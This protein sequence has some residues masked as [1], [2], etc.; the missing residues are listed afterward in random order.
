[1]RC[2]GACAV[3]V[4][5]TMISFPCILVWGRLRCPAALH[6]E[7]LVI[8]VLAPLGCL[9]GALPMLALSWLPSDV[10]SVRFQCLRCPGSPRM[11]SRCASNACAVLDLTNEHMCYTYNKPAKKT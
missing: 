9:L 2:G 5:Y 1:M 6:D 10:F 3:L 4:P 8:A 7:W 11:S